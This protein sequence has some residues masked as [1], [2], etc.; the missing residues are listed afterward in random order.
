MFL[1]SSV[2]LSTLSLI[3]WYLPFKWKSSADD[4]TAAETDQTEQLCNSFF[5]PQANNIIKFLYYEQFL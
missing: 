1:N 5:V 3:I 4:V 2:L